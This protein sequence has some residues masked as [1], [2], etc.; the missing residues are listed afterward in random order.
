MTKVLH[1]W[2][3]HSHPAL[4]GPYKSCICGAIRRDKRSDNKPCPRED[5]RKHFRECAKCYRP[6]IAGQNFTRYVCA[7]CK[8][9]RS[10]PNTEIPL[11]CRECADK[12]QSCIRCGGPREVPPTGAS[13]EMD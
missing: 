12:D 8:E 13:K 11:I 9:E 2:E 4:G 5:T 3:D 7:R 6:R 10:H 1:A